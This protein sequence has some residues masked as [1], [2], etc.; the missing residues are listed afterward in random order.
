MFNKRPTQADVA[1]HVGVSQALVSY[2]LNGNEN[3]SIP[4]DTRARILAAVEEL[5]YVPNSTARS[6]RTSKTWTLAAIIPDITNP[7]Y[8]A[9]IRGVQ[10]VADANAYDIII[11][12]TDGNAQKESQ[13]LRSALQGRVDGVVAV[14]FHQNAK[15]LF[16]LLEAGIAVVRLEAAPKKTGRYPLDTLYVD[17][18]GAACA[19]VSYLIAQGHSRIGLLTKVEG[20]GHARV[21]GYK[22]ALL[23][24]GLASDETLIYTC[25]FSEEGGYRG[26]QMLLKLPDPPTAIFAASDVM[27]MGVL[28]AIRD[29]GLRVPEDI[30]VL[31]FDNIPT[32]KL[33]HP[34]LTTVTQFQHQLGRRAAE[35][36]FERFEQKLATDGRCEEMPYQVIVRKS[37]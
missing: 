29:V 7:F 23:Q 17:N 5:G 22:R 21:T 28:T 1:R 35:M 11:Y 13:Y 10:D 24:H 25:D 19:A 4:P 6:L 30:A 37:A 12:N 36:L 2:V 32:A 26:V 9:F 14:L 33:V 27:A 16:P 15:H 3:V 31:G 18:D 34:S 8:P 20:P